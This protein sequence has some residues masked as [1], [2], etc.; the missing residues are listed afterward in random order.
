MCEEDNESEA[1]KC[2]YIYEKEA[3]QWIILLVS[4]FLK[5]LTAAVITLELIEKCEKI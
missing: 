4:E 1:N 5:R 3:V 2:L